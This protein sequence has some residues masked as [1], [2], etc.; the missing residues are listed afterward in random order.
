M[1][2][3]SSMS[4]FK[5]LLLVLMRFRLSITSHDLAIILVFTIVLYLSLLLTLLMSFE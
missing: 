5:Q 3:Y 4:P 1:T 2:Y